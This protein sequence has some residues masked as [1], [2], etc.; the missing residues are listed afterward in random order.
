MDTD[1]KLGDMDLALFL[2][3]LTPDVVA[4]DRFPAMRLEKKL[5]QSKPGGWSTRIIRKAS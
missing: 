3:R 5:W 1:S 4:R 2:A